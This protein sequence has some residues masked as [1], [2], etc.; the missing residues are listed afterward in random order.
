MSSENLE[1]YRATAED[2]VKRAETDETFA[3]QAKADP[4]GTLTGAG[5]PG[6]VAQTMLNG[7]M[8]EVTGYM[9]PEGGDCADTTCW[10]SACPG[11]C[12]ISI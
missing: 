4:L 2:L 6:D 1:Q 8:T 12:Y 10:V 9:R 5:I 3:Q 7:G 11:T